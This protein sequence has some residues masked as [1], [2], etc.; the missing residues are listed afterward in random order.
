MASGETVNEAMERQTEA[1]AEF[2]GADRF[3]GVRRLH[4]A[5]EVAAQRGTIPQDY[6]VAR[7]AAAAFHARLRELFDQKKS[8]TSFGPYSPGQ[9]VAMK[10]RGSKA[11]TSAAGRPRPRARSLRTRDRISP[12]IR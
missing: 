7:E 8:I 9:A 5:R 2:M 10:R 6:T 4:T 11:S 3:R 12:A 1:A